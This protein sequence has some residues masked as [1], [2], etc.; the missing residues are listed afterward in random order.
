MRGIIASSHL[1]AIED[2][3]RRQ[4]KAVNATM[5]SSVTGDV[6]EALTTPALLKAKRPV[7][8][9]VLA[10]TESSIALAS[11]YSHTIRTGGKRMRIA[12]VRVDSHVLV[13]GRYLIASASKLVS[14]PG[15]LKQLREIT[16]AW[17]ENFLAKPPEVFVTASEKQARDT[18][19]GY[20][21]AFRA[22]NIADVTTFLNPNG[23][24]DTC[25]AV[26][27][28]MKD[29]S[30]SANP[31]KQHIANVFYEQLQTSGVVD[32]ENMSPQHCYVSLL[33]SVQSMA[34]DAL[35]AMASAHVEVT[36]LQL[37][38]NRGGAEIVV[39]AKNGKSMSSIQPLVR[40]DGRWYL[41]IPQQTSRFVK[42]M[43]R[44]P[45]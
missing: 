11:I 31:G 1:Q 22:E 29:L 10:N 18:I 41:K 36:E 37:L 14:S 44:L 34:P 21:A 5:N 19:I 13:H 16:F 32:H 4:R 28:V 42:A 39:T 3:P 15:D 40:I 26:L 12:T 25:A 2:L 9:G 27:P 24:A 38:G 20:W 33:R 35:D 30:D 6:A 8:L 45:D 7:P 17:A 23:L 43:Q